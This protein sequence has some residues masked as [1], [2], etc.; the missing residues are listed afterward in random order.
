MVSIGPSP[1]IRG[2][3]R[4]WQAI[5]LENQAAAHWIGAAW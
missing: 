2:F 3:G 4:Q 5:G 1:Q